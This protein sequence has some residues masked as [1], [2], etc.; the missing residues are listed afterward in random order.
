MHAPKQLSSDPSKISSS[1]TDGR[2]RGRPHRQEIEVVQVWLWYWR[3]R[4]ISGKTDYML[5]MRC[6][7]KSASK[8]R[9]KGTGES[10]PRAFERI[11]KHGNNPDHSGGRRFNLLERVET[12]YPGTQSWYDSVL[13]RLMRPPALDFSAFNDIV[14]HLLPT[15]KLVRPPPDQDILYKHLTNPFVLPQGDDLLS[16][17]TSRVCA[18]VAAHGTP[19]AVALLSALSLEAKSAGRISR[20]MQYQV[21]C[22]EAFANMCENA[23]SNNPQDDYA[24]RARALLWKHYNDAVIKGDW[25]EPLTQRVLR[26]AERAD[27]E[28]LSPLLP[29]DLIQTLK[30]SFMSFDEFIRA[31]QL[32]WAKEYDAH[33]KGKAYEEIN[34]PPWLNAQRL[35][36]K[37]IASITK[38][39]VAKELI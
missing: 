32:T 29:A 35:R 9:P 12:I 30:L 37:T 23:F 4:K 11:R 10:R 25:G 38:R 14:K 22:R 24:R 19:D 17:V 3:V 33:I 15:F 13:W 26:L 6:T 27:W 8:R 1:I 28:V 21:W 7:G 20:Q 36:S 31:N 5:D 34:P 39:M 2:R 18:L 16:E